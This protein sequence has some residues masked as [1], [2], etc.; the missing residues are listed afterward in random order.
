M[1][2]SFVTCIISDKPVSA[3]GPLNVVY[4]FYFFM[5]YMETVKKREESNGMQDTSTMDTESRDDFGAVVF[6]DKDT[7]GIIKA[8]LNL[9][10]R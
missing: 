8:I 10:K 1:M 3:T 7:F 9:K 2:F 4:K 5:Y 6:D